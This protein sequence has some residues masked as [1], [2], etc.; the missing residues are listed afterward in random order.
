MYV[1]VDLRF[2]TYNAT[3]INAQSFVVKLAFNNGTAGHQ[4]RVHQLFQNKDG[5]LVAAPFEYNGEQIT[6]ADNAQTETLSSDLIPGTYQLLVHKYGMDYAN[7]EEVKPVSITLAEDGKVTGS[8]TGTWSREEGTN[9]FNIV[10]GGTTYKGVVYEEQMDTRST[11]AVAFTA[12]SGSG[13]NVWGYKMHPKYAV[14]WQLN[15]QKVPVTNN[16]Q[17]KQNLELDEMDL[18]IE[19]VQVEWT[20]D[21][22]DIVSAHG[23]YNPTG[24]TEDTPVGLSVRV[25]SCGYYWAQDYTVK[26][27]SEENAKTDQPWTDGLL[28]HYGFDNE[29]LSNTFDA[30][31]QAQLQRYGTTPLPTLSTDE[32]LRNG[33]VV[34]LS[35][36]ANGRES[37]VSMPNPLYAQTLD[38]GAT[39][40]FWVKRTDNNLWDA[41]YAFASGTARL[42]MTGNLYTG[43]NDGAGNWLDINHPEAVQP[44]NLTVG[45]WHHVVVTFSP[46]ATAS[47]GGVMV[48]VDGNVKRSDT[49]NGELDGTAVT[50]KKAF[51]YERLLSLIAA[52]QQLYLGRGSFWGSPDALFDDVMVYDRVLSLAEVMGLKQMVNRVFDATAFGPSAIETVYSA[53]PAADSCYDLQGRRVERPSKGLYIVNGKKVFIK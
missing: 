32:P 15:N 43:Y 25:S 39:L 27:L 53:E 16:Q 33:A 45:K 34:H 28:A 6:D 9:Y 12:A 38:K 22:P 51:E 24:L 13:V 48:Y 44:T 2:K 14:A 19:N 49:F 40:A 4:V 42:Y 52:S 50:T 31:Q 35:A 1:V 37:F 30:T 21:Q 3:S 20:S 29:A 5:W 10:M 11:H 46:T 41:L 26:A 23:R 18:Q 36:G 17:V 8:R 47:T 7:Y